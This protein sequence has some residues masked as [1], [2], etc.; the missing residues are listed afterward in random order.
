M[1]E[2]SISKVLIITVSGL[3]IIG[4]VSVSFEVLAYSTNR[5]KDLKTALK[6]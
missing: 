5:Y 6:R 1:W 2:N 3:A 4:L